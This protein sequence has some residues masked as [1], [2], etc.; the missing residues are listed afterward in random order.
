M[1][2]ISTKTINRDRIKSLIKQ[3]HIDILDNIGA[4][5]HFITFL[6]NDFDLRQTEYESIE[7][8][9]EKINKL[10]FNSFIA[11]AFD[12]GPTMNDI[13]YWSQISKIRL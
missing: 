7:D 8:H 3:E 9:I 2:I 1:K 13:N 10:N 5:E 11:S 12:W 4:T 6:I